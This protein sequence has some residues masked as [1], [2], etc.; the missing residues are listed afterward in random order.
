MFDQDYPYAI[1]CFNKALIYHKSYYVE[2]T[3][4]TMLMQCYR[5]TSDIHYDEFKSK[6][7]K[8][9][10]QNIYDDPHNKKKYA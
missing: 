9:I 3:S 4:R 2:L 5:L 1:S 10:C 8:I 6:L 7:S